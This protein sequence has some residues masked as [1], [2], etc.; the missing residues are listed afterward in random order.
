MEVELRQ[1]VVFGIAALMALSVLAMLRILAIY[2]QQNI[3]QH[4]IALAVQRMRQEYEQ[5]IAA[6]R[7]YEDAMKDA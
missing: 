2:R 1:F 5:R 7:Q 4:D 3:D 6:K